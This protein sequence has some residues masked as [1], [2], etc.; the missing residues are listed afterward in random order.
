MINV[1][2]F[3]A[4]LISKPTVSW[5]VEL[6]SLLAT[7]LNPGTY[8][9][10]GIYEG[11]TFNRVKAPRKIAV[12]IVESAL[13]FIPQDQGVHK[14]LGDARAFEQYLKTREI[15]VDLLFIDADH[16]ALSVIQDFS[17]CEKYMSDRGVILLH[18]TFPGTEAFSS[19]A[20][21]GDAYKAV[22]ILREKFLDWTF[23]TLPIHP[24]L[25]IATRIAS[26]PD[27]IS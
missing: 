20:F 4:R 1:R 7:E 10:L 21:C 17:I 8:A 11:E 22:P 6:I 9:E 23:V 19:P 12:D 2:K 3:A 16:A 24:G 14:V 13:G 27:W 15:Q 26:L 25:T 18:D 5:H